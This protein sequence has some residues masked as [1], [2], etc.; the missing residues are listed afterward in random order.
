ILRYL[1]LSLVADVPD[2][3]PEAYA[4]RGDPVVFLA[5]LLLGLAFVSK[6]AIGGLELPRDLFPHRVELGLDE[7]WRQWELVRLVELVEQGAL[8]LLLRDLVIFPLDLGANHLAQALK[9]FCAERN[10]ESI[11]QARLHRL[12]DLLDLDFET[13]G[14]AF[15]F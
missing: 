9:V 6:S 13:Y 14:F 7:R 2:Q 3:K 8:H 4:P 5:S 12:G 15:H 1:D 11:V 10:G